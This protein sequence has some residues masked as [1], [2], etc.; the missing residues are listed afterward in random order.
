[1]E[2]WD[3]ELGPWV[4]VPWVMRKHVRSCKESYDRLGLRKARLAGLR[5]LGREDRPL[6]R[7]AEG[8]PVLA[9]GVEVVGL[10]WGRRVSYAAPE[11]RLAVTRMA[12][13][14]ICLERQHTKARC[15]PV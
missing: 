9:S 2:C 14:Q 5:V 3:F 7:G 12:L 11:E 4:L 8:K 10:P 1:M 15:C 6:Q 13:G